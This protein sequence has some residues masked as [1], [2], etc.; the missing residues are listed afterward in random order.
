MI[1]AQAEM[2]AEKE[3]EKRAK[4][5][6]KLAKFNYKKNKGLGE[7]FSQVFKS[8]LLELDSADTSSSLRK[9]MATIPTKYRVEPG[10][11]PETV[12]FKKEQQSAA[13]RGLRIKMQAARS[14]ER[15]DDSMS[16]KEREELQNKQ[17]TDS[18]K[19]SNDMT[20]NK[21]RI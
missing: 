4:E 10:D 7:G 20:S 2:E 15:Y 11:D 19:P 9:Q 3:K 16:G 6:A 8:T 17:D 1:E 12:R 21:D 18:D 13:M 14:K 5:M